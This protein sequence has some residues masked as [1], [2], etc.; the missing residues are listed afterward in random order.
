MAKRFVDTSKYR[1]AW[2]KLDPRLRAAFY[3]LTENS[4]AAGYWDIDLEHFKFECG[5]AL[6]I[7]RLIKE[8]GAVEKHSPGVLRLRDFIE[9][10]YV[11]LKEGYNPHKPAIR[12]LAHRQVSSLT[13]ASP[14]LEDKEGGEKEDT[15][16]SGK[17]RAHE[18]IV[19]PSF[20]DFYD[21]YDRKR[22]RPNA[23]AEWAKIPQHDRE[24]IM[25]A[26]PAYIAN[27]PKEYRKDPERYLKLRTWEDEV[28]QRTTNGNGK[29]TDQQ[30]SNDL[31]RIIAQRYGLA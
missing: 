8:T 22:G 2:R 23:E 18:A 9:V 29:P 30:V 15:Q 19:W 16:G 5:Y 12:A 10:N 4:D 25:Q 26:V 11:A 28:I 13:Q 6:D 27:N 7:E 1:Q 17:E 24:A 31:D 20:D 21:L 14:K 3:W